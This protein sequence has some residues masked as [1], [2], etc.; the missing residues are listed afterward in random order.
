MQTFT[1]NGLIIVEGA[2]GEAGEPARSRALALGCCVPALPAAPPRFPCFLT[3]LYLSLSAAEPLNPQTDD[4]RFLPDARGCRQ[5]RR[6]MQYA[7]DV[8]IHLELLTFKYPNTTSE[9]PGVH[10]RRRC[11]AVLR[12]ATLARRSPGAHDPPTRLQT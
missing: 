9:R 8:V 1:A 3:S 5:V 4:P 10:A 12:P 6:V 2:L 11:T 7:R